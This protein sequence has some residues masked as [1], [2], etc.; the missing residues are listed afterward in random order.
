MFEEV[1]GHHKPPTTTIKRKY[2]QFNTIH[3]CV[4]IYYECI[5]NAFDNRMLRGAYAL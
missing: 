2:F 5:R 3:A 4:F 1:F